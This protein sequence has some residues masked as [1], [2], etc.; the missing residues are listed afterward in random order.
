LGDAVLVALGG[1][2]GGN[3][4]APPQAFEQLPHS[5]RVRVLL[6]GDLLDDLGDPRKGPLVGIEA[7]RLGTKPQGM[8]DRPRLGGC[9]PGPG[10]WGLRVQRLLA[11]LA[12]ADMPLAGGLARHTQPAGD[13][14]LVD[15]PGE[16]LGG[17]QPSLLLAVAVS[18][19]G[20]C[21]HR[22]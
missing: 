5:S 18:L 3:L 15:A 11:A 10:A 21:R 4:P 2:S 9:Q 19:C 16:Q 1:A 14:G 22:A 12:P 7:V 8:L 13:L 20:G 6:A 17:L